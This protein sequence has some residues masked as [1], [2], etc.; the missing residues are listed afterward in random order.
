MARQMIDIQL[1]TG[2]DTGAA[3]KFVG[4]DKLIVSEN[5]TVDKR[6]ALKKRDGYRRTVYS[7]ENN[8]QGL[9]THNGHLFRMAAS[10]VDG[11]PKVLNLTTK[12]GW[13]NNQDYFFY[14]PSISKGPYGDIPNE[15]TYIGCASNNGYFAIIT[16]NNDQD[17]SG[18]IDS[19]Y[20]VV[21]EKTGVLFTTE[22]FD[23]TVTIT[24]RAN[25][26]PYL[27]GFLFIRYDAIG[28]DSEVHYW[29]PVGKAFTKI[30]TVSGRAAAGCVIE[31]GVFALIRRT[32][33]NTELNLTTHNSA[34][35]VIG[36]QTFTVT[37]STI[38]S[39]TYLRLNR[40]KLATGEEAA[41]DYNYQLIT[42]FVTGAGPV[43]IESMAV[44]G[45]GTIYTTTLPLWSASVAATTPSHITGVDITEGKRGTSKF[46]LLISGTASAK[47]YY[48]PHYINSSGTVT[49]GTSFDSASGST[50]QATDPWAY[51]G[52]AFFAVYHSATL[53]KS[54]LY[55]GI[56]DNSGTPKCDVIGKT[57]ILSA[58]GTSLGQGSVASLGSGK[59]A[60]CSGSGRTILDFEAPGYKTVKTDEY[61]VIPGPSTHMYYGNNF[62][63]LNY[64]TGV[65][66]S[67]GAASSGGSMGEGSY[68]YVAIETYTDLDGNVHRSTTSNVLAAT[69]T[70]VNKTVSVSFVVP[71][72]NYT[73][74]R[75]YTKRKIHLYRT[76][77]N[78]STYY[79]LE[80]ITGNSSPY[81]DS[82]SDSS[83]STNDTIYTSGGVLE[84]S[85]VPPS[86]AVVSRRDRL[87]LAP[88][89]DNLTL[90]FSKPL[91]KNVAPE[92]SAFLTKYMPDGGPITG[93][94]VM[95]RYV[96][97]FKKRRVFVLSGEGP[98]ALGVG[99]FPQPSEVPSEVGCINPR[100]VTETSMG[101]FFQSERGI[102]L[103]GRGLDIQYVGQP[104]EKYNDEEIV[105]SGVA[106]DQNQ[107]R[108]DTKSG[109]TLVYNYDR[110][111]LSWMVH[112]NNPMKHSVI[113]DGI[114]A[115]VSKDDQ[116]F[117]QTPGETTDDG[118]EFGL[119][120]ETAWLSLR[121]KQGYQRIVWAYILGDFEAKHRLK[122]H[123][124]K[125]YEDEAF[126]T[127]TVNASE[128]SNA[129]GQAHQLRFK[130]A[131]QK[132]QAVKFRI[133]ED[134]SSG[135]GMTLNTISMM[136]EDIPEGT[137]KL[138]PGRTK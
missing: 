21:D 36:N 131:I 79:F 112:R 99:N 58:T 105:S 86:I 115:Y 124:Y 89:D 68:S 55:F 52:G 12:D 31:G 130:P 123:L 61:T 71:N 84:A 101:V 46:M 114:H 20:H 94:A 138:S 100:S 7:G 42:A 73:L 44:K 47:T 92:F 28:G 82:A 50:S 60:V 8:D 104:V 32:G 98:N 22:E 43:E 56:Y 111:K 9:F 96:V 103:L 15:Y 38:S 65:S 13:D 3:D 23:N 6:G 54:N 34:G 136:L 40:F 57:D 4:M 83:I 41:A 129:Q 74:A 51:N 109:L 67:G 45:D 62:S 30:V 93:L 80:D 29:E 24:S 64:N 90:W 77:V 88:A 97:I 119:T 87:F 120:V 14:K 37:A 107:V 126:Q 72:L 132:M 16:R 135:A 125:D 1:A 39:T 53:F 59:F 78:G 117:V 134:G 49:T 122:L 5:G 85:I 110:D 70:A 25:V 113:G 128:F 11:P 106:P 48:R 118:E 95:D 27:D 137:A 102:Y 17:L 133:E 66:L 76:L 63:E 10:S 116:V 121:G 26:Y 18:D 91:E 33:V 2:I 108:F 35:T 69:T 19:T 81:S 75:R 127:F